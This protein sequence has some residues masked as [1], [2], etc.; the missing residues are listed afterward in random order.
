MRWFI[1]L[2]AAAGALA[3]P[4]TPQTSPLDQPLA[5]SSH[6]IYAPAGDLVAPSDASELGLL[7]RVFRAAGVPFGFEADEAAPRET[8]GAPVEAHDVTA[9]T[10]REALD[11][12]V[13]MDPRYEWRDVQGVFVVRTRAAWSDARDALNR[14]V[15]DVDWT[16]LDPIALFNRVARLLYPDAPR[17]P[18]EGMLLSRARPFA[19]QLRQGTVLDVLNAAA[20]ADGQLG[21]AVWY[22]PPRGTAR[23]TL[24]IGH[25]GSGPSFSWPDRPRGVS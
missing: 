2:A 22:G 20:R 15:R 21:W 4:R 23:F 6:I 1:A 16:D 18:F 3:A 19:V 11:G 5:S 14:P 12:F 17:D 7:S 9:R 8:T 13:R 10:L 25:F 24:T